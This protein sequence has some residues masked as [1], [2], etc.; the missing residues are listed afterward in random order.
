MIDPSPIFQP[1]FCFANFN[2][3]L[4]SHTL[5]LLLQ[6]LHRVQ[7]YKTLWG[8]RSCLSQIATSNDVRACVYVSQ[9]ATLDY[10]A[11]FYNL[12]LQMQVIS[13]S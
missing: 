11:S 3:P 13:E 6:S 4:T 1:M 8:Q 7:Y 9:I 12:I 10:Y 2:Q 5:D